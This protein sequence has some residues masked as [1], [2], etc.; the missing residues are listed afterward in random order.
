VVGQSVPQTH[1]ESIA[2]NRTASFQIAS[3]SSETT[4]QYCTCRRSPSNE[5][6]TIDP[7]PT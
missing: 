7:A 1:L 2:K 4:T 6:D 5:P 3:E